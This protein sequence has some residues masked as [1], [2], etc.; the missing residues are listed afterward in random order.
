MPRAEVELRAIVPNRFRTEKDI[1]GAV[2][3]QLRKSGTPLKRD[4]AR[5]T[6]TWDHKPKFKTDIH[7]STIS[8]TVRT[9]V[10]TENVNYIRIDRGTKPHIIGPKNT[11]T[12]TLKFTP[13][14]PKTRPGTLE[15]R[16]SVPLTDKSVFVRGTVQHPGITPR[17]FT[18]VVRENWEKTFP[19]DMQKALIHGIKLAIS[20]G[21]HLE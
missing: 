9:V 11:P 7:W 6:E 2:L 1:I 19:V 5:P 12:L 3:N 14:T 10:Y 4:L 16:P 21:S 13:S 17:R 15:S 18:E 20:K 8:E